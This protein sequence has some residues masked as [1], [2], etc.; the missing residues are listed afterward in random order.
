MK[1]PTEKASV[2]TFAI[3]LLPEPGTPVSLDGARAVPSGE[4]RGFQPIPEKTAAAAPSNGVFA[5]GQKLSG[6]GRGGARAGTLI[7]CPVTHRF[8]R[9]Q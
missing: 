8:R 4:S 3:F 6:P 7:D 1:K 2:S 5:S 9:A